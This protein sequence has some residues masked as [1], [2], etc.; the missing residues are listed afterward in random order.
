MQKNK[1]L[2]PF[3]I[4]ISSGVLVWAL[5]YFITPV[6]PVYSFSGK[7]L[8][9]I[10]LSYASLLT[11]YFFTPNISIKF[12]K[13][14]DSEM[15][16]WFS[17]LIVLLGF[18][19]RFIDL[20]L[21][22]ELAFSNTI[23]ENRKLALYTSHHFLFLLGSFPKFLFF[24][25]FI[26][27]LHSKSK[28]KKLVAISSF[29]FLLPL[30]EAV[31]RGSRAPFLISFSIFIVILLFF[32][33]LKFNKKTFFA[34]TITVLLLFIVS[35]VLLAKRENEKKGKNLYKSLLKDARYNDMIAPKEFIY[36]WFDQSKNELAKKGVVNLLQ[37]GQY[38]THAVFEFNYLLEQDI[39]QKQYGKFTFSIIPKLL[40]H[41]GI[42]NYDLNKISEASP[43]QYTF[44]G[45]LGGLYIDF[46]WFAVVFLFI[47]GSF[48]KII[49]QAIEKG[50]IFLFPL[51]IFFL[52]T[53]FFILTFNFYTGNG[54]SI[55]IV[56]VIFALFN[57]IYS[58]YATSTNS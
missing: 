53:N 38:Y 34:F 13:K 27:A 49:Y 18:S 26:F 36:H 43:R 28:N 42:T 44:I 17:I 10:I 20:F 35:S 7:T 1:L 3:F 12:N 4:S 47:I 2:S 56:C 57:F 58:R 39:S 9:F 46:G 55:L 6:S 22:R 30:V 16:A 29:L 48:Q 54:T 19:I 11:G 32:H 31:L 8:L 14:I 24:V 52:F 23:N 15:L 25:P 50:N 37:I 33:K 45:L 5:V 41:L 21:W 51:F 40:N